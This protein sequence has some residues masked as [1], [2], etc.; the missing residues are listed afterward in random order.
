MLEKCVKAGVPPG[1]LLGDLKKGQ[2]VTLP[3]G[4][5]VLASDVTDPDDPGPVFIGKFSSFLVY[6]KKYS[7]YLFYNQSVVIGMN[8]NYRV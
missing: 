5:V 3:N 6:L 8:N 1:P 4:K 2:D 7:L